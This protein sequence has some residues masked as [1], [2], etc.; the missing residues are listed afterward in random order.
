MN[1]N[2]DKQTTRELRKEAK[3]MAEKIFLEDVTPS[4]PEASNNPFETEI[5]HLIQMKTERR[6]LTD[7]D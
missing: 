5:N 1:E 7:E 4:K 6:L 3:L 2:L